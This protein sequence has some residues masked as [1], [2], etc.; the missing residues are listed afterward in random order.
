MVPRTR[1]CQ[2][3]VHLGIAWL[4]AVNQSMQPGTGIVRA[5]MR[6]GCNCLQM[7]CF[8]LESSIDSPIAKIKPKKFGARSVTTGKEEAF[9]CLV[10]K[11]SRIVEENNLNQEQ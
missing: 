6:S 8:W 11:Y 4:D 10:R 9:F 2:K 5:Q 1:Q 7:E 3:W